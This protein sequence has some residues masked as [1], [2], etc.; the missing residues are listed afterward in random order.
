[1]ADTQTLLC[2]VCQFAS[3][4]PKCCMETDITHLKILYE[5][6]YFCMLKITG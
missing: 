4:A 1:M 6:V 2:I 5:V 3:E